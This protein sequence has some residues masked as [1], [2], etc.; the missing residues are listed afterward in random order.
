MI[1]AS[2]RLG[3]NI[4]EHSPCII[5][6][7]PWPRS[8]LMFDD[9][10][11]SEAEDTTEHTQYGSDDWLI[12][13]ACRRPS[14]ESMQTCTE[15]RLPC[16]PGHKQENSQVITSFR[17][18][19]ILPPTTHETERQSD[20]LNRTLP[21]TRPT[22]VTQRIAASR[23]SAERGLTVSDSLP[24]DDMCRCVTRNSACRAGFTS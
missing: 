14:A 4:T 23:A 21:K 1:C 2:V 11:L 18:P 19:T 7:Q 15:H 8:T 5:I 10:A 17:V 12:Q 6:R 22:A 20:S 9:V 16:D 13:S 3:R 24:C